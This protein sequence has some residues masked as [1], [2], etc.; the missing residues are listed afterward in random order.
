MCITEERREAK[1][2]GRKGKLHPTKCR[3]PENSRGKKAFFN[4]QY[5][6]IEENNRRGKTRELFKKIGNLK[7][8]F[9]P[10]TGTTVDR[11]GNDLIE[12]EKI[13][14]RLYV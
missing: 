13:K 3:V 10:K 12:A 14:K 2:Q 9:H 6:E 11:N 8:T 5:K 1:K 7:G 4:E